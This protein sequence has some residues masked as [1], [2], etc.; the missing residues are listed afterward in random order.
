MTLGDWPTRSIGQGW[1]GEHHESVKK[2]RGNREGAGGSRGPRNGPFS[3]L[4]SVRGPRSSRHARIVAEAAARSRWR[5]AERP[6]DRSLR[7]AS[8]P[9]RSRCAQLGDEV[10]GASARNR[11]DRSVRLAVRPEAASRRPRGT[12]AVAEGAP[13]A[14]RACPRATRPAPRLRHASA[15]APGA[16]RRKVGRRRALRVDPA[17]APRSALADARR[18]DPPVRLRPLGDRAAH[19]QRPRGAAD[20][21][22]D[23]AQPRGLGALLEQLLL[24]A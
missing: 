15:P 1:D 5:L 7:R 2:A 11:P 17:P 22:R 9:S 4:E 20:Q 23:V 3:R 14:D 10:S 19:R 12:V 13:V 24:D 16:P 6:C 8:W 18:R 21:R